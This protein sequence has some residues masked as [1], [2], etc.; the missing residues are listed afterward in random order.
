MNSEK[1]AKLS[2]S[3]RIGGKGSPR[4]KVKKVHHINQDK[5]GKSLEAHKEEMDIQS[6]EIL[7]KVKEM[8]DEI[9]KETLQDDAQPSPEI[10]KI[11]SNESK[12]SNDE[13]FTDN[14]SL[15]DFKEKSLLDESI[16]QDLSIQQDIIENK[17]DI[18]ETLVDSDMEDHLIDSIKEEIKDSDKQP[19]DVFTLLEKS[20]KQDRVKV[21]GIRGWWKKLKNAFKSSK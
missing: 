5:D 6:R 7:E 11:D 12:S 18:E 4:R 17:E 16:Q 15:D 2:S 3:V 19:V 20:I 10:V 21:R 8:L 1:L 9:P 14:S 13:L